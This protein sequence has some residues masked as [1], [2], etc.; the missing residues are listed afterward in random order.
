MELYVLR[1]AI[2]DERDPEKYPDDALRPLTAKGIRR[3]KRIAAGMRTL[4]IKP[5]L[6]LS[7]PYTR[8]RQT[9]EIAAEAL[10]AGK[11]LKFSE[12]LEVA[13]DA[14]KLV[15]ELKSKYANAASV[16]LV[17]HEPQLSDCISVLLLGDTQLALT[18]KKGG[19]CKLAVDSLKYGRCA[20]LEW[21]I[22]PAVSVEIHE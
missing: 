18:M 3:M 7:S 13:G 5:D 19:L 16:I 8:A 20:T 15:Q 10:R 22:P 6:I 9:A 2:A 1:H 4:G 14:R 11:V 21:L 17:G 12:H